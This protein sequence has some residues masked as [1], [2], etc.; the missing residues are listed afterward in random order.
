MWKLLLDLS[1]RQLVSTI[2]FLWISD[3]LTPGEAIDILEAN[4]A[5]RSVREQEIRSKGFPAYTDLDG[6]AWLLGRKGPTA[7]QRGSCLR[8]DPFQ[9][10]GRPGPGCEHAPRRPH[11]RR[12]R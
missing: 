7:V 5:T 2:D 8:L 10:E 12:D 9:D 3:A 11:A 1:P 4:M 6:L